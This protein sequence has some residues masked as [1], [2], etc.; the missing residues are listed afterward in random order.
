MSHIVITGG[1]TGVGAEIAHAVA[2]T[3]AKVTIMGRRE[4]PLRDHSRKPDE[5]FTAAEILCGNVP[6]LELFARETRPGWDVMGNQV[7]CFDLLT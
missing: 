5:A 1:G 7:G 4:G 6:R 2:G 3:G